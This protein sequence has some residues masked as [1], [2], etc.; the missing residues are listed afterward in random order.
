M[1]EII[2]KESLGMN[3]RLVHDWKY[4]FFR[5]SAVAKH[6]VAVSTNLTVPSYPCISCLSD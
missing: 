3:L 6:M 1:L 5:P 4:F 2:Q